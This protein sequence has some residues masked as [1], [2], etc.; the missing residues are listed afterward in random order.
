ML[1]IAVSTKLYF[2]EKL[3][4]KV[5]YN[6][7][8]FLAIGFAQAQTGVIKG[9]VT[10]NDGTP[11]VGVNINGAVEG[12]TTNTNGF[13]E[14]SIPSNQSVTIVFS[15]IAHKNITVTIS[16]KPNE[17]Y[18]FHPVLSE[19]VQQIGE[20]IVKNNKRKFVEGIQTL[21]PKTIRNLP[22]ANAGVENL[23]TSLPGVNS[24][25]ELSTQYAVRGGNYDENLVY[26]NEIEI[27]RPFLIRSGQQ[28]GLSF[29][30]SAM[31]QNV[32]FS[33]GGFQSKFGDKLS[34]VLDI[35]YKKPLESS[36][37]AQLSLLGGDLTFEMV[38]TKN[39]VSGVTGIRYRDNSLL[40]NQ[41]ETQTNYKPRFA[42]IQSFWTF[43]LNS[44]WTLN[45]LG[46]L[47][48]NEYNYRPLTRQTNFG[49]IVEPRAL[50]VYY[51][52]LEKDKYR[53]SS[54]AFKTT[55][56]VNENLT[57]KAIGSVY[58]TRESENYDILAQYRLGEP[59]TDIG[60]ESLGEVEYTKG[61]GSQL[62]HARNHLDGIITKASIKGI[63]NKNGHQ[64]DAGISFKREDIKDR[65]VEWEVIDSAG[66]SI[67]PNNAKKVPNNQPYTPFSGPL[68]A[69]Q[70]VRATNESVID[71]VESYVQWSY[72]QD[73][74]EH[75]VWYHAGVRAHQWSVSGNDKTYGELSPRFQL[76]VKPNWKK[77]MLFRFSIGKYA[78]PPIY[79]ELRDFSGTLQP[80]VKAQQSWHYLIANEYSFL[81]WNRPFKLVSEAYYKSLTQVNPYTLENV[82]IRYAAQNNA[83][84]FATGL[85][86]RLNG[87][88][89]PGTE[90]WV[91]I[92]YLNTQE[93][94]AGKG[95]IPRP[96][97]QRLKFAMLFQDYVPK[98]PNLKM[99]L[100]LIYNTGLP[101]GSPS[102]A[103]PYL[104]KQRLR[105]YKRVDIGMSYV[106]IS[107]TQQK[108]RKLLRSIKEM[109]VGIEIF[110]VFDVQNSITNTWVRDVYTKQQFGIPNYMTPRVFNVKTTLRF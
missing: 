59:S 33:A 10:S 71:R 88:F 94:T 18:E 104:Y 23:L 61:V 80:E 108:K 42:D 105:D 82:R 14:L 97:D 40:V 68:V 102:N 86:I 4:N 5:F 22:G 12:T 30:N 74:G 101:G 24:N 57:L 65:I 56:K 36:A 109:T 87:E 90:S 45:L 8:I 25:N 2:T 84:A 67:R 78:Q 81:L 70:N 53:T 75:Q 96:T 76:A 69:Y 51:E 54:A 21:S 41:K 28:E 46:S 52:G 77:D 38:N 107:P 26:V 27:Y 9:V 110:N 43:K 106:L 16:L 35:T 103:D 47:S 13:Y 15:H 62:T 7:F 79:K 3:M 100:N 58:H 92:G 93:N 17:E 44:Q 19:D 72:Q 31:I 66:F 91:S 37:N 55:Y 83:V 73:W 85:D 34:S 1:E 39:T 89:V 49:T 60:N 48:I 29:L 99:N 95:Y 50:V 32:S 64:I 98:M 6:L 11:I 63:Y 20:V